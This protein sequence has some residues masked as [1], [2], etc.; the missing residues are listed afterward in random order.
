MIPGTR[1]GP[2]E[3]VAAGESTPLFLVNFQSL[4]A[5]Y[6]YDVASDG[7]SFLLPIAAGNASATDSRIPPTVTTNWT[8][9]LKKK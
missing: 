5:S 2:Y 1:L 9:L 7:K 3:V 8:T 6:G 4:G